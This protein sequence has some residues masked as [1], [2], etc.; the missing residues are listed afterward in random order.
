MDSDDIRGAKAVV[1]Y[2]FDEG[3]K[4]FRGSPTKSWQNTLSVIG[5]PF[6]VFV[7]KAEVDNLFLVSPKKGGPMAGT[8]LPRSILLAPP[9]SNRSV[10]CLL[11]MRWNVKPGTSEFSLYLHMFGES[12]RAGECVWHR[13]YRLELGHGGS[14]HDYTHVQP[15]K[16]FGWPRKAVKFEDQ[17]VPDRVPAFP[18]RGAKLTTLCAALAIGLHGSA[19][20]GTLEHILRGNRTLLDVQSLLA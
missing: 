4:W 19:V 17:S 9:V 13:G 18:V 6:N 8:F 1:S 16:A 11:G 10:V 5:R 12:T 14:I 2:L 3:Q 15:V 20:G 7:V